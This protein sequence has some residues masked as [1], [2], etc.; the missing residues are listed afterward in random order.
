MDRRQD[1]A[2]AVREI[3]RTET[4]HRGAHTKYEHI[5]CRFPGVRP[6]FICEQAELAGFPVWSSAPDA[7]MKP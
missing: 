3:A 4:Y 2:K 1:V 5:A 7:A 6:R